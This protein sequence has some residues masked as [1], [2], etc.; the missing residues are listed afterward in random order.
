MRKG[1]L[2]LAFCAL[3]NRGK[4]QL[5]LNEVSQ[6]PTG[7]SKEY[8][9]FV[10]VGT[11]TCTDSTA[12]LRGWIID[13]NNG[14]VQSGAGTGIAAGAIRFANNP[15]WARVPYGSVILV[16]NEQ[17][18]NP[19]I[20]A[21]DDPTDANQDYTYILPASSNLLER[22]FTEPTVATGGTGYTY[23]T[24]GFGQVLPTDWHWGTVAL[25]N[26]G[27]AVIIVNPANRGAASFSFAFG[28][29]TAATAT[30]RVPDMPG[31]KNYF[32]S[33]ANYTVAASWQQGDAGPNETPGVPNGG[34][35][36][37]WIAALR[38]QVSGGS[39]GT[40][41]GGPSLCLGSTTTFTTTG[42]A[43]GTWSS[44]NPA[45]ATVNPATGVVTPVAAGTSTITYTVGSG[46]CPASSGAPLTVVP[47]PV[48]QPTTG[49]SPVCV[50]AQFQVTNPAVNGS[51]QWSSTNPAVATVTP[52]LPA[53]GPSIG[54][55][56]ALSAGTTTI[57][58]TVTLN[59]CTAIQPFQLVV[60]AVPAVAPITGNNTVCLGA[61]TPFASTTPGGVWSAA[62]TAVATVSPGG[63]VTGVAVGSTNIR[64]TVT[65]GGCSG[66]VEKNISVSPLP[67]AG[68][69]SG[70]ATLCVGGS[71]QLSIPGGAVG[72][73]TW[74][75]SNPAV[76]TV[77]NSGLVTAL[78]A[79]SSTI[80]L[81]V[82]NA[83]GC[84][85]S[86]TYNILVQALSLQLQATPNPVNAGNAVT[87]SATGNTAF[88]VTGWTP[89][90]PNPTAATQVV[91]PAVTTTYTV[92]GQTAAGC[93]ASASVTVT[94]NEVKD[95]V[96][97]PNY[98]TPNN[99]GRNDLLQVYGSSIR[100]LEFR[101]FN[102][103]GQQVF[104]S[105]D[106]GRG[107]DGTAS[108]KAQPVGVYSYVARIT[109][110]SGKQINLKGSINL[111]R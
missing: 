82:L 4:A 25:A 105:T 7:G 17:D 8:F 10:V 98:F 58:L 46:S 74:T 9:E 84:T 49:T 97:I 60:D 22:N 111:I 88:I 11:R 91:T 66:F 15:A 59:G 102:Q 81:Q 72:V 1:L 51:G 69:I 36:S 92:N 64:Y 67:V 19:R 14:W 85:A 76:A 43:G 34:A 45:V 75:S 32:L 54:N 93:A 110:Q 28:I 37:T 20:T 62:N 78:A 5:V 41:S 65:A 35:N 40:V 21:P 55:V 68:P 39:A 79:G 99:D 42:P 27:D 29:G 48:L 6:G 103:W 16:Y 104:A 12:D 26:G 38:L 50:G 87:L 18:K 71:S 47:T 73:R 30:I 70:N 24:S 23:P 44:S 3:A 56:T 107:W 80:S 53:G 90:V 57:N 100:S 33:D 108:G 31:G 94:V 63:V 52:T 13:D 83:E 77:N 95:D 109:L 101:I 86:S 96:F 89:S 106:A 2:L 61:T